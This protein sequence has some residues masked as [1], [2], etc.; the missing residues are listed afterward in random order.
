MGHSI[1]INSKLYSSNIYNWQDKAYKGL[2]YT[3]EVNQWFHAEKS[4]PKLAYWHHTVQHFTKNEPTMKFTLNGVLDVDFEK[5]YLE[6]TFIGYLDFFSNKLRYKTYSN[7]APWLAMLQD[8][9]LETNWKNKVKDSKKRSTKKALTSIAIESVGRRMQRG[10]VEDLLAPSLSPRPARVNEGVYTGSTIAN[11]SGSTGVVRS[12]WDLINFAAARSFVID[13]N[14]GAITIAG[15]SEEPVNINPT[16]MEEASPTLP[17]NELPPLPR[18]D[19][20]QLGDW[21]VESGSIDE[22]LWAD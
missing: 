9:W 21:D 19:E 14:T 3:P 18:I 5:E 10:R 22:P 13:G 20:D 2:S 12:T 11:T 4:D 16:P 7:L 8:Y 15:T 6:E 17:A 1:F